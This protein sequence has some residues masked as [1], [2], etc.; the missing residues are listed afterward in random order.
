M[1]AVGKVFGVSS[2]IFSNFCWV[3]GRT[4]VQV[5]VRVDS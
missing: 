5:A 2:T 3:A 1:A 4:I